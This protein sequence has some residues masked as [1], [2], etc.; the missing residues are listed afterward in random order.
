M[1]PVHVVLVDMP[2]MLH[3]IIRE[4]IAAAPGL[5][6]AADLRDA[7]SLDETVLSGP[8]DVVIAGADVLDTAYVDRLLTTRPGLTVLTIDREG[9]ETVL[10][11]LR[12]HRE[13]LGELSPERLL[14]VVR[15]ARPRAASR[16]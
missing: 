7:A 4:Q 15:S 3:D 5:R 14:A 9:R 11:E 13:R 16:C 12:P 10:C 1:S 2:Q 6:V 8:A